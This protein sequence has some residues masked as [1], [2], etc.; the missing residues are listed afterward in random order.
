MVERPRQQRR[1]SHA[2]SMAVVETGGVESTR[3][4]LR[5]FWDEKRNDRGGLL[6]I[7]LNLSALVQK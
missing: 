5:Q 7:G 4:G 6:F 2:A 1:P 3:W